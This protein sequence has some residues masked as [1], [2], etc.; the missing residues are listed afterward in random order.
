[1]N[2]SYSSRSLRVGDATIELLETKQHKFIGL[3]GVT[4][5][6]VPLRGAARPLTVRLDTPD[7]ILY[8]LM[9]EKVKQTAKGVE[10]VL[11]AIGQPLESG[12]YIDDYGQPITWLHKFGES[13]VDR[14]TLVL[15]PVSLD[16][17]GRDWSG[18]SYEFHFSSKSRE[19][20]RLM[21]HA[22]WEIG[23]RITGNTVLNQGQCNMPVYRGAKDTLFTTACLRTLEQHGQPHGYS[24]QLGPRGG[25]VQGFDFQHSS[26]GALLQF[27]PK[28]DSIS[29]LI[30]SPLGSD[31]LHV[32]DEYRFELSKQASTLPKWVLFTAGKFAEHEAR[33]LWWDAQQ[34]VHGSIRKQYGI[35]PTAVVPALELNYE[36]VLDGRR[37]VEERHQRWR[38]EEPKPGT[39]VKK[40][41]RVR[42]GDIEVD[43]RE[44]YLA[45][46]DHVLPSLAK[47][48]IRRFNAGPLQQS[49]I[50]V[51]GNKCKLEDGPHGILFCSSACATHQHFPSEFWGGIKGWR[52]LYEKAHKLGME[53]GH[54]FSPHFSPRSPIFDSHPEYR[55]IDVCGA[56]D[57][58]GYGPWNVIVGDWN[59]GLRDWVFQGMKRWQDEGGLD[60]VWVDSFSNMGM[61]QMNYSAGMRT[62]YA[63]FA[64]FLSDIQ[65]IGIRSLEFECTSPL[66]VGRFGLADLRG[67]LM[68]RTGWVAGQNDLGWWVGEEDMAFNCYFGASPRK[69]EVKELQQIQFRLMANRSY[70]DYGLYDSRIILPDWWAQN[71]HLYYQCL[72]YM[73]GRRRLLPDH[74]GVRWENKQGDLIWT[75]KDWKLDLV[76]KQHVLQLDGQTERAWSK[77]VLPAGSVFLIRNS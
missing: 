11:R 18:F 31:V 49:D 50:T 61:L 20:H 24:F 76:A 13:I 48:G 26:K 29:S 12:E 51:L 36:T 39:I 3:G 53:V 57:G 62:N 37:A 58:G 27:W 4:I 7:G 33:D 19:I 6:G 22:T 21:T 34:Y 60:Y 63:A 10:I 52:Y 38:L 74:A 67:D 14:L 28:F 45:I 35:A 44:M 46:A 25:L 73:M 69:R 55:M 64:H 43:H 15:A 71:I 56:P 23:G 2:K 65:G 16:V 17:G 5:G 47:Q 72:P 30:E 41:L 54:W 75:F 42:L 9:V 70:I 40:G 32:V 66:G 1:M 8:S 77:S 68:E 59:T